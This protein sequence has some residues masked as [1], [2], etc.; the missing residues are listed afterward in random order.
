MHKQ[1]KDMLGN[2]KGVLRP[3]LEWCPHIEVRDVPNS[4]QWEF[5]VS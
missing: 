3:I 5:N 2:K 1:L 4:N